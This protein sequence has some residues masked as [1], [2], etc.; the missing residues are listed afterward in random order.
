MHAA[1]Q[2]SGN[3]PPGATVLQA[4][5]T[6]VPAGIPHRLPTLGA[7]HVPLRPGTAV[8]EGL[9]AI[10]TDVVCSVVVVTVSAHDGDSIWLATLMTLV[11]TAMMI[12]MVGCPGLEPFG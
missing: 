7:R 8:L 3:H 9:A 12:I 2:E 4:R 1:A 6:E 11:A 10:Q 5:G